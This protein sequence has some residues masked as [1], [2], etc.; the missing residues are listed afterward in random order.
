MKTIVSVQDKMI[1]AEIKA[2]GRWGKTAKAKMVICGMRTKARKELMEMGL[3]KVQAKEA[4]GE[5]ADMVVLEMESRKT[6][7]P[8]VVM[9]MALERVV[10]EAR[11]NGNWAMNGALDGQEKLRHA[12][13]YL[14]K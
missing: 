6:I 2:M 13:R 9:E 5:A 4:M 14:G 11:V 12:I 7:D 10:G 8:V 1:A 3:T